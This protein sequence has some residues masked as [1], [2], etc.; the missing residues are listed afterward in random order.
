MK[1]S[2]FFPSLLLS[3]TLV[4]TGCQPPPA[5]EEGS[6][7]EVKEP[8]IAAVQEEIA[9][10]V[11]HMPQDPSGVW[12]ATD[13]EGRP[14]DILLYAN[15]QAIST[16]AFGTSGALG[17]RGFWRK[18]DAQIA[19]FFSDGW[20]DILDFSSDTPMHRGYEPGR[21]LSQSP[22][23][24]APLTKTETPAAD[25]IGI[26]RLNKEPDGNYL[27]VALLNNGRALSTINGGT[28]GQ[29]EIQNGAAKCTWP[30]GWIDIIE[31]IDGVWR[32]RSWV[33]S[34]NV[35]TSQV[36]VSAA[37]KVGEEPFAITP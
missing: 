4:F 28:E 18:K 11:N 24:E 6:P 22:T 37:V 36:D 9:P 26:W 1:T 13:K 8:E 16:W 35:D 21:S 32:K 34:V 10:A 2:P 5:K 14:F 27:Y 25:F 29:W 19:V 23:N 7:K 15:G 3:I 12:S 17:E 20:T 30:D 33:G 31:R